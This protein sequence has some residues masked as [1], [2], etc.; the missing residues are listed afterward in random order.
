MKQ[1][2]IDNSEKS[3]ISEKFFRVFLFPSFR[4]C[5]TAK[6]ENSDFKISKKKF[7]DFR[8]SRGFRV[9]DLA[10]LKIRIFCRITKGFCANSHNFHRQG[11]YKYPC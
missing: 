7:R 11:F 10:I 2:Q 9:F 3:E 4:F 8:D 1:W 5:P 6:I